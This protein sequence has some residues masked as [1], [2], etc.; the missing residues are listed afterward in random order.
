M[1]DATV[2]DDGG[3]TPAF[4]AS[5]AVSILGIMPPDDRAFGDQCARLGDRQPRNQFAVAV[6]H[7]FDIGEQASD[8]SAFIAPATAPAT[9]SALM[10]KVSPLRPTPMGAITG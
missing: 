6:E 3:R 8:A 4:T 1:G 5:I 10:L 9:V 2:Q 7:A